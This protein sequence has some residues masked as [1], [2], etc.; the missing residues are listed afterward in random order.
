MLIRREAP[1][2]TE[3][4]IPGERGVSALAA[5]NAARLG[6]KAYKFGNLLL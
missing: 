2:G 3:S 1:L 5:L 4:R 6:G